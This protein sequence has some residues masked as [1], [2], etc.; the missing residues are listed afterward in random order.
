MAVYETAIFIKVTNCRSIFNVMNYMETAFEL[1]I[2]LTSRD[3][4]VLTDTVDYLI[5]IRPGKPA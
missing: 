4:G 5:L 1:A 3:N 2:T